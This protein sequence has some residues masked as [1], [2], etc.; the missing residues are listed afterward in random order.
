M[1]RSLSFF[2]IVSLVLATLFVLSAFTACGEKAEEKVKE[3]LDISGY[4]IVRYDNSDSSITKKTA[5]LKGVIK[6]TLGL[7]L[8]VQTDW[9]N[10]SSAPDPNAKEILVDKT[11]RKE[12]ADA[13]AKLEEKTGDAY[14]IDI[15]EN[16]IVIV[17]MTDGDTILGI[18]YFI[19]NYVYNSEKENT[20]TIKKLENEIGG[21][22]SGVGTGGTLIGTG[23]RLKEYNNKIKII[24]IS[25]KTQY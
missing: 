4:T 7:E 5:R 24:A 15:T 6:D 18:K 1:K 9:Y 20:V 14:I 17:G 23:K 12:S 8:T 10:P 25:N 11:N 13:L 3:Y 21:F 2:R 22:V 16:K 19:N